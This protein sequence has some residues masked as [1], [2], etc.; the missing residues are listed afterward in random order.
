MRKRVAAKG[1]KGKSVSPPRATGHSKGTV[2]K[3]K[4]EGERR[5]QTRGGNETDDSGSVDSLTDSASEGL[6]FRRLL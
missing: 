3:K 2:N 4:V 6:F 5:K 1:R